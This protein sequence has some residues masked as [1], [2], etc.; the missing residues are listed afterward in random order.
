MT[1]YNTVIIVSVTLF[2]GYVCLE[3]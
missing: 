3:P 1:L 2:V